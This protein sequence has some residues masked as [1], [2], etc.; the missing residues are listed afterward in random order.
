MAA[1][2]RIDPP[3]MSEEERELGSRAVQAASELNVDE[4]DFYQVQ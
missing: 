3:V 1:A 4:F 2:E